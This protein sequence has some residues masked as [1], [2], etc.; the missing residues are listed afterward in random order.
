[1]TLAIECTSNER[2]ARAFGTNGY[3]TLYS[4][5]ETGSQVC[6]NK[7]TA[8]VQPSRRFS[9]EGRAVMSA[10]GVRNNSVISIASWGPTGVDGS[11]ESSTN[12]NFAS[13]AKYSCS[14][15]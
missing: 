11:R 5:S 8:G 13:N 1:M 14:S 15:R 3:S 12:W 2:M 6:A 7:F 10:S 9:G 4:L